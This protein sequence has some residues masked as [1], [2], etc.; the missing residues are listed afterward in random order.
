MVGFGFIS[1]TFL[2]FFPFFTFCYVRLCMVRFRFVTLR[3]VLFH[4]IALCPQ[5]LPAC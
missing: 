4:Y 5:P 3:S 1:V 2:F